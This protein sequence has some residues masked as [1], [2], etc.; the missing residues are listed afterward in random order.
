MD[1]GGAAAGSDRQARTPAGAGRQARDLALVSAMARGDAT[2][3]A[4]FYDLY[5]SEVYG[6]MRTM[7]ADETAAQDLLQE[8]MW[9]AWRLAPRY[10][11]SRASVRTWLHLILRSRVLDWRRRQSRQPVQAALEAAAEVG[12]PA[13]GS[14]VSQAAD[15]EDLARAQTALTASERQAIHLTYYRG[16]SQSEAATAVGVPLGT[17][18]SRVRSALMRLHTAL[19]P[20]APA[21]EGCT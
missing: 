21:G 15:R 20:T 4:A 1:G 13:A 9:Q 10:D 6:L 7:V 12:D 5:A 19:E 17:M 16:L 11:A 2:A 3:M 8:T 18:K 14:A